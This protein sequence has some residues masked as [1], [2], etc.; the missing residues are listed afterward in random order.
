MLYPLYYPSA[1]YY[2]FIYIQ[3][4]SYKLN[5]I[6]SHIFILQINKWVSFGVFIVFFIV[7]FYLKFL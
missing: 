3:I 6:V 7:V 5:I 4:Y 1:P 2:I